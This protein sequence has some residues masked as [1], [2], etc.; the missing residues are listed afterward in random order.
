[1]SIVFTDISV[2]ADGFAVAPGQTLE[3][4]FGTIEPHAADWVEHRLHDWMF[5][6]PD[7]NQAELDAIT[8]A[9]AFIMGRNMFGPDRGEPDLT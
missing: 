4:P 7:E 2:S 8:D 9:G 5:V 1:M 3:R 6:T